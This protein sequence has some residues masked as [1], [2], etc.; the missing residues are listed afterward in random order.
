MDLIANIRKYKQSF[1]RLSKNPE[2]MFKN[3]LKEKNM[4]EIEFLFELGLNKNLINEHNFMEIQSLVSSILPQETFPIIS[5]PSYSKSSEEVVGRTNEEILS[6]D[7]L[8]LYNPISKQDLVIGPN[9]LTFNICTQDINE[10]G[11]TDHI[12]HITYYI[13]DNKITKKTVSVDVTKIYIDDIKYIYRVNPMIVNACQTEYDSEGKVLKENSYNI[14]IKEDLK[15]R[16]FKNIY[17]SLLHDSILPGLYDVVLLVKE[18]EI[19][20]ENL[21]LN[22]NLPDVL[23]K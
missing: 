12:N 19:K 22:M 2:N 3:Y 16:H 8:S 18:G 15:S 10:I 5:F 14:K 9:Y 11:V 4:N 23:K 6:K 7:C 13:K 21:E 17:S 20:K 1:S